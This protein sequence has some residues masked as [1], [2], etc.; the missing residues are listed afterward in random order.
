[1]IENPKVV[2]KINKTKIVFFEM[3]KKKKKRQ[4]DSWIAQGNKVPKL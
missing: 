2:K 1:M 3:L 4:T